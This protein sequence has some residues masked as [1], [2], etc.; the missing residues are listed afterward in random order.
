[1]P[2]TAMHSASRLNMLLLLI[3]LQLRAMLRNRSLG[4]RLR[5]AAVATA[6]GE[7]VSTA[8]AAA[9]PLGAEAMPGGPARREEGDLL[10]AER[11]MSRVSSMLCWRLCPVAVLLCHVQR[12]DNSLLLLHCSALHGAG[13]ATHT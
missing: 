3:R 7:G 5:V 1:M 2:T 9:V 4:W 6:A 10:Q 12:K 11:P 13:G 8:L